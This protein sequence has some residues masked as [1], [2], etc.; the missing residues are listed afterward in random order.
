LSIRQELVGPPGRTQSPVS[1]DCHK[2]PYRLDARIGTSVRNAY[3]LTGMTALR[4][5]GL[6][7][8]PTRGRVH[9][10]PEAGT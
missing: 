10:R 9:H 1:D 3:C 4:K 5:Q 7:E 2:I 8:L 6:T